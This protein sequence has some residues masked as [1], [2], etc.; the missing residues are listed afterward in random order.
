VDETVKQEDLVEVTKS[1]ET[2]PVTWT[3]SDPTV[4]E[5]DPNTGDVTGKKTGTVTI[6]ATLPTGERA[7]YTLTV[8][9]TILK[10]TAANGEDDTETALLASD[11]TVWAFGDGGVANYIGYTYKSN[12]EQA[13]RDNWYAEHENDEDP[14]GYQY[15]AD[16]LL[17]AQVVGL[18]DIVDIDASYCTIVALKADGTVYQVGAGVDSPEDAN[19]NYIPQQVPGLTNIVSVVTTYDS[20]FAIDSNGDVWAWGDYADELGL[21]TGY[22]VTV[23]EKIPGLSNVKKIIAEDSCKFAITSGGDVW[24]WD[25][26]IYYIMPDYDWDGY[27]GFSPIKLEGISNVVDIGT[28]SGCIYAVRSNGE[29]WQLSTDSYEYEINYTVGY[30]K[31]N[32]PGHVVSMTGGGSASFALTDDGKLYGWGESTHL[33]I[34]QLDS[35]DTITEPTLIMSNV[36]SVAANGMATFV[37]KTDGTLWVWSGWFEPLAFL[38]SYDPKYYEED[39]VYDGYPVQ[40]PVQW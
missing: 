1:P 19:G 8:P 24:A 14:E 13:W 16:M 5:V 6:T 38:F 32:V 34:G 9:R 4:A 18:E 26:S 29:V 2:A 25:G 35:G 15:G 7:S 23:P 27:D 37:I 21:G 30:Q 17:S 40:I 36:K 31:I 39:Y 28:Y 11:G 10:V 22:K 20:K 3:S 12:W 33:G